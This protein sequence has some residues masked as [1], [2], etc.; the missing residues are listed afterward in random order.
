MR[1]QFLSLFAVI[2]MSLAACGNEQSTASRSL[3]ASKPPVEGS[4]T[5]P[6][7]PGERFDGKKEDRQY[8]NPPLEN[9]AIAFTLVS[10]PGQS[11][12]GYNDTSPAMPFSST[13]FAVFLNPQ[14]YSFQMT[15]ES[16][17]KSTVTAGQQAA[18]T[19]VLYVNAADGAALIVDG[20]QVWSGERTEPLKYSSFGHGFLERWWKGRMLSRS[21]CSLEET[22]S[23]TAPDGLGDC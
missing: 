6:A 15:H 10:E 8:Y 7:L 21:V 13:G 20:E 5:D 16:G 18:E 14:G 22:V 12:S 17:E 23:Y 3:E 2:A 1:L 11:A 19:S 9:Y 4:A